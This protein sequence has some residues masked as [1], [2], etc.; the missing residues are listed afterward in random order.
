MLAQLANFRSSPGVKPTTSFGAGIFCAKTEKVKSK[1]KTQRRK[2][3]EKE[4]LF[5]RFWKLRF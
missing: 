3:A 1:I 2:D 5:I 4:N